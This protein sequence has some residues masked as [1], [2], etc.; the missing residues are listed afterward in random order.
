MG[1]LIAFSADR[2][3]YRQAFEHGVSVKASANILMRIRLDTDL[4]LL[5]QTANHKPKCH[6]LAA[7]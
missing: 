1:I 2:N 5:A 7:A 6:P 4:I 3:A